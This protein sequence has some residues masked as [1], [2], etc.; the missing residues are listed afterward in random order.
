MSTAETDTPVDEWATHLVESSAFRHI[1]ASPACRGYCS[2]SAGRVRCGNCEWLL[3]GRLD[4]AGELR[5][6]RFAMLALATIG[7]AIGPL[8]SMRRVRLRDPLR[9]GELATLNEH[10]EAVFCHYAGRVV[11]RDQ[12]GVVIDTRDQ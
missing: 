11:Y 1:N 9:V 8:R 6:A 5:S 7:A 12:D 3:S 4:D 2:V 10:G